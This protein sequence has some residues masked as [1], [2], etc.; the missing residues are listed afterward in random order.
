MET[1]KTRGWL[2]RPCTW[3]WLALLALTFLAW[4][5]AQ[6]KLGGLAVVTTILLSTLVKGQMVADFF[7]GLKR[8]RPLWRSILFLYLFTIITLVWLA[9]FIALD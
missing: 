8:V 7:M 5:V 2:V 1:E 3:V 9:Y 6:M 4:G